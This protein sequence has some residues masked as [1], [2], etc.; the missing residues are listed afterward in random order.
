MLPSF[1]DY[2][3]LEKIGEGKN[4][5]IFRGVRL[6]DAKPV[7]LKC[8]KGNAPQAR[9]RLTHEYDLLM[10]LKGGHSVE[11]HALLNINSTLVLIEE[12]NGGK[13]L[14]T[15]LKE[16]HFDLLKRL[17]IAIGIAEAVGGIHHQ[18][19]IHKDI[20]PANILI[21]PAPL[22]IKLID[23]GSATH[24]SRELQQVVLPEQIEGTLA[25]ISPEQTG[26]LNR[27][28]DYRSDLYSL[29]VTLYQLFTGKLPFEAETPLELIH[30]HLA[31]QPIAPEEIQPEIPKMLSDIILKCLSKGV[32]HRY[33]SAFGLKKDLEICRQRLVELSEIPPFALGKH[34]FFDHFHYP[35]RLY[36]RQQELQLIYNY[37]NQ[38]RGGD[39]LLLTL[40]G[41]A[42][43]GKS[44][45][46][47]EAEKE[48]VKSGRFIHAKIDPFKKNIPYQGLIDVL[49]PL[50]QQ[51]LGEPDE[52]LDEWKERLQKAVGDQ[53]Q[54]IV[55][56]VP[57]VKWILGEQPPTQ[58]LPLFRQSHRFIYVMLNFLKA[59]LIAERPL[60]VF[61]DD[62]QW[63][64]EPSLKLLELFFSD[65]TIH[66]ILFIIGYR[67][68]EVHPLHPIQMALKEIASKGGKV[69]SL[70]LLPIT[71]KNVQEMMQEAFY[72]PH[73]QTEALAELLYKKTK[74]NPSFIFQIVKMLNEKNLF[75]FDKAR[76]YWVAD[77]EK[78]A[79]IQVSDNVADLMLEQLKTLDPLVLDLLKKGAC[80]VAKFDVGWL[81][82]CSGLQKEKIVEQLQKAEQQEL[83][84]GTQVHKNG[85]EY[86]FSHE[87]IQ[88]GLYSLLSDEEKS[89]LH[90][91]LG[92]YLIETL[93]PKKVQ[94]NILEIVTHLNHQ[95]P[96]H[97]SL[98]EKEELIAFN[99][100][101]GIKAKDSV[102]YLAAI[103]YFS[104]GID[105]LSDNPWELQY[106]ACMALHHNLA[107][108]LS[109]TGAGKQAEQFF[110]LCIQHARSP[111]EMG[112]LSTDL[113]RL[114]SQLQDYKHCFSTAVK[115]IHRLG[116]R[117]KTDLP[118]GS[119]FFEHLYLKAKMLF[120][121]VQELKNLPLATDQESQTMTNILSGL[122]YPTFVVGKN[123]LFLS[124]AI[125]IILITLRKGVSKQ[126]MV[127]MMDY[128]MM[129]SS[130][131][132]REYEKSTEYGVTGLQMAERF[133]GTFERAEAI[134]G[135]YAFIHR[136]KNPLR[137]SLQP[138]RQNFRALLENGGG[139]L[140]ATDAV[141]ISMISLVT[142]E[143]LANVLK[144]IQEGLNEVTKFSAKA[145]EL[146]F[147]VFREVCLC[148]TGANARPSDPLPPEIDLQFNPG[149]LQNPLFLLR[150]EIWHTGLLFLFGHYHDAVRV[151]KKVLPQHA[152]YPNWI[153]WHVFYFFHALSLAAT[154]SAHKENGER[155]NLLNSHAQKLKDWAR[156]SPIN[157]AH[158][159][160]LVEAEILRIRGVKE[161]AI[162]QYEK[163]LESAKKSG[164]TQD[165]ALTYEVFGKFV[166]ELNLKEMAGF[167]LVKSLQYY[168]QWGAVAKCRDLKQTYAE[169]LVFEGIEP[170]REETQ[171]LSTHSE[172]TS[173]RA[174]EDFDINAL[175]EASQVL[176][177]EIVLDK[178]MEALM[179]LL[180][181]NAGADKAYLI[182]LEGGKPFVYSQMRLGQP[183]TPLLTPVPIDE[184]QE[185]MSFSILKFVLRTQTTV[186]LNNAMEEGNFRND[187]YVLSTHP[188]SI[189]CL[190]L[191]QK[192]S[193]K[194][195]LYLENTAVKGAF[196]SDRLRLL[197]LLSAQMAIA[198]EN[199]QFYG[200][201]E[202]KV[203]ERTKEL[204]NRNE[205]LQQALL[206]I[207]NVQQQMIQQE[208]LAS[209]GLLTSGIAHELKN[210]L[211]FVINFSQI[212][213]EF[214]TELKG[215]LEKSNTCSMSTLQELSEAI[216]K[217][218]T[219]GK[220]ADNIIQAM[221]VQVHPSA[222]QAEKVNLNALIDQALQLIYQTYLKKEPHFKV[223]FTK[224]CDPALPPIEGYPGDLLRVFVNI[225]DNS[226]YALL[227]K[228]HRDPSFLPTIQV[229]TWSDKGFVYAIL[230]DNGTGIPSDLIEKIFD[231][232]FTTKPTGL[233]TG[234]GLSVVYDIITKQHGGT[235]TVQSK[236]G[237]FTEFTL[238]LSPSQ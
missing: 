151:G 171:E 52:V 163:A 44:S 120:H 183:Y 95:S 62:Y 109:I 102:A 187:P 214:V 4:T 21:E 177:K 164:C 32:E 87:R 229:R 154:L 81:A 90:Y 100:T 178:L 42:G 135:Y 137:S 138:L 63:V 168:S 170:V 93:T 206:T 55:D 227:E 41:Y 101:A 73:Q 231:P 212:A 165:I 126:T 16:G 199:A 88:Q 77:L 152:S 236:L 22:P 132:F 83:L 233:G 104:K 146:S 12:D 140:A 167:L 24:L 235:L 127:G 144:S 128:A 113:I 17:D 37:F 129:L 114:Y 38:I 94:E 149:A 188:Q 194:G 6:T 107:L 208:K 189:L 76:C 237:E 219:H 47:F 23:F 115:A 85:R 14:T 82:L 57:E 190:A 117:Y 125:K 5:W 74:G 67:S 203:L 156:G 232:F 70:P 166:H 80:A 7:I 150:Y 215:D 36:G 223:T 172:S 105:L 230:R 51:I 99:L 181:V 78:I 86:R 141:Y 195:L 72:G 33:H 228:M 10:H 121:S 9:E 31:Q 18:N 19:I 143:N 124:N 84:F 98:K 198:L 131:L 202:T 205:E 234:L 29:G 69:L 46:V 26:R 175:V 34:D 75:R 60:V 136:W 65:P 61:I 89:E 54:L 207:K 71:Q 159:S 217:V 197:T 157:Y 48:I 201:L 110:D 97:L 79:Q 216:A 185:E 96:L 200:R 92:R 27:S 161:D 204:H 112:A 103:Q 224:A 91:Q 3:I 58:K 211:N 108:C 133:P 50:I 119:V 106:T 39:A 59:F 134:F 174:G 186:V 160:E 43:V 147:A 209:L 2:S 222:T 45:L 53:G 142:G 213:Q 169:Y 153:E 20:K 35:D 1:K 238:K 191:T 15:L 40:E 184:K 122:T 192:G 123:D 193:V 155:W 158:Y 8:L 66:H 49:T 64:D 196:T 182:L 218:D 221:L 179:H 130:N 30:L 68:N 139:S 116:Y 180:I 148:L 25:Y 145:E 28:M 210:P 162:P 118:P 111:A 226:Y 176:S 56:V 173:G 225:F 11:A 13:T 220:R